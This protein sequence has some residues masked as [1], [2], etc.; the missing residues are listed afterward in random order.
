MYRFRLKFKDNELY[1]IP[2]LPFSNVGDELSG[3]TWQKKKC[4]SLLLQQNSFKIVYFF[5]REQ[6]IYEFNSKFQKE[7]RRNVTNNLWKSDL[8]LGLIEAF[9]YLMIKN[10]FLKTSSFTGHVRIL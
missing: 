1:T 9:C 3:R 5:Y 7:Q 4:L 6:Q 2:A 10:F 8:F